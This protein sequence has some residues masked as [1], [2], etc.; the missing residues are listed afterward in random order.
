MTKENGYEKFKCCH[1]IS[2][3]LPLTCVWIYN[4]LIHCKDFSPI[5]LTRKILNEDHYETKWVTSLSQLNKIKY[6]YNFLV[7]K[8]KGY[9]PLFFNKC[10]SEKV[11]ILHTHFGYNSIKTVAL[12]KKLHIP[13]VCSFYG[14][15]VYLWTNEKKY[16]E[17]LMSLFQSCELML[18][19]GP[20][21]KNRLIELG[22]PEEKIT[23]HHL[24]VDVDQIE[25]RQRTI[26][27]APIR[28]LLASSF[29][30]KKGVDIVLNALSILNGKIDF[31]VDIIGDGPLK[32]DLITLTRELKLSEKV[33]YYGYKDYSFFLKLALECHV[34]LQASRTAKN[35]DKE[36]TPMS[37][38]DAMATGLPVISTKHSDIPEIVIDGET[39]YLA[40]ENNVQ[41][42]ANCILKLIDNPEK[43]KKMNICSRNQIM[44]NFNIRIQVEKLENIY[45]QLI[46]MEGINNNI[47]TFY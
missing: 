26:E 22:C 42:F 10:K 47:Y 5:V 39:G 20:Y 24:G 14:N 1:Y 28:F 31:S 7:F 34:F 12:K 17:K 32:S 15:D 6:Y 36:G 40:E 2:M 43:Y 33:Y 29:V 18:V 45:R 30:D 37:I 3:Y 44:E 8:V 25:Y 35:G 16:C 4:I 9:F 23:I 19:L 41:D 11:Q 21:M 27:N 13:M 46:A 38:V